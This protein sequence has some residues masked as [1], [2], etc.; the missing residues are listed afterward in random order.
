MHLEPRT[1][2]FAVI[3]VCYITPAVADKSE[4]VFNVLLMPAE[5]YPASPTSAHLITTGHWG[6]CGEN[7]IFDDKRKIDGFS[8][9][10]VE[11]VRRMVEFAMG[12]L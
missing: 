3:F 1:R 7:E 8:L 2:N 11:S 9:K 10:I 5:R 6:I 12:I 4:G